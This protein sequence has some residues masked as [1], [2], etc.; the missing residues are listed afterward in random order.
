MDSLGR[1][2]VQSSTNSSLGVTN[3]LIHYIKVT[4]IL[5]IYIKIYP[6]DI[7][8][9]ICILYNFIISYTIVFLSPATEI[10]SHLSIK[11]VSLSGEGVAVY[12]NRGRFL[13]NTLTLQWLKSTWPHIE[14][15]PQVRER[16]IM[17]VKC[18]CVT[19]IVPIKCGISCSRH[20]HAGMH[21]D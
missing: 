7:C 13:L 10:H 14:H 6:H 1:C 4:H 8:I 15:A 19:T 16:E 5:Y 18:A 17:L 20:S 3:S 2:E 21:R 9:Y 12:E 11:S